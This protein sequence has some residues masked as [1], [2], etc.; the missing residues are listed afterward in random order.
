M[1]NMGILVN[2][3]MTAEN[4]HDLYIISMVIMTKN[5]HAEKSVQHKLLKPLI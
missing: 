4:F 5:V 3:A 1:R 2:L